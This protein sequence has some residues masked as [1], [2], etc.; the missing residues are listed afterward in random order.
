M[1]ES[2]N[3]QG[4]GWGRELEAIGLREKVCFRLHG[5]GTADVGGELIPQSGGGH[6]KG[7]IPKGLDAPSAGNCQLVLVRGPEGQQ[8]GVGVEEVREVTGGPECEGTCMRVV[9]FFM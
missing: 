3:A 9:E 8:G 2:A 4:A 7:P 1:S 5:R 6:A